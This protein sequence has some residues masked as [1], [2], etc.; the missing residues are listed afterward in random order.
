MTELGW[1]APL[2]RRGAAGIVVAIA[3]LV[4][5]G[6]LAAPAKAAAGWQKPAPFDVPT[7]T[8]SLFFHYPCPDT[9][10]VVVSGGY[11]ANAAGQNSAIHTGFNGP[12]LN[13]TPPDFS[14]W[15]WHFFWPGSGS[16]KGTTITFDV[17]CI[18]K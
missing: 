3:A 8:K 11:A 17:Y 10:P 1:S 12:L 15:G 16:P 6:G 14:D 5:A 2:Y 9:E 7:G 13:Q 4:L 18:T